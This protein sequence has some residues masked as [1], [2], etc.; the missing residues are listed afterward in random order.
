MG[1]I[2]LSTYVYLILTTTPRCEY[3]CYL[4]LQMKKL[5]LK[6]VTVIQLAAKIHLLVTG[7]IR[8][9]N[10]FVHLIM[11]PLVV[12]EGTRAKAI[13]GLHANMGRFKVLAGDWRPICLKTG[14][15]WVQSLSHVQLFATPWTAAH[16]ASLSITNSWNLLKLMSI[17]SVMPSNHLILYRPLLLPSIFPGSFPKSQS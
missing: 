11:N 9:R 6:E 14:I 7:K 17:E 2:G 10:N 15:Q 4:I 1:S 16:Q 8:T 3:N 12:I 5:S 13:I